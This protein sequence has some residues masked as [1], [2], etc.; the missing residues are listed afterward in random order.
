MNVNNIYFI[1][2]GREGK[3]AEECIDEGRI[4]LGF[5]NPHHEKCLEGE[6]EKIRSFWQESG[7]TDGI[8]TNTT[9]QIR[10]FYESNEDDIWITNRYIKT[11]FQKYE[12]LMIDF[13]IN[14]TNFKL[15]SFEISLSD[16]NKIEIQFD[17]YSY[18]SCEII[19]E[20]YI[21]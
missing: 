16:T 10:K 19:N 6:W 17:P 18:K 2:L 21:E 15:G 13:D 5:N 11:T 8:A 12:T 14:I 3:W 1:K 9:N 7:K 4:R 20:K